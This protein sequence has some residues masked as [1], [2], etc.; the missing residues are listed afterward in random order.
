MWLSVF[1]IGLDIS[2]RETCYQEK[3]FTDFLRISKLAVIK[4]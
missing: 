2:P 3:D 1:S 4:F